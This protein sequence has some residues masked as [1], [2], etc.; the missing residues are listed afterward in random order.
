VIS[1]PRRRLVYSWGFSDTNIWR[2]ELLGPTQAA[3]RSALISSSR[4]DSMPEYSPDG[5]RVSFTSNRS[6]RAEIWTC[7]SDGSN[8]VQVTSLEEPNRFDQ[9]WSPDG[10]YVIFNSASAGQSYLYVVGA[11]GGKAQRLAT[12]ASS[13]SR[14]SWSRDGRW[15]YFTSLR[16][17]Q[18]QVWKI[19][20]TPGAGRESEAVQVTQKGGLFAMESPDGRHVY[21]ANSRANPGLWRVPAQR[22]EEIQVLPALDD[23]GSFAVA[24]RGIYF[25]PPR[26]ADRT[27]PI[28]FLEFATGKT[29]PVVTIDKP[30]GPRLAVSPDGRSLLYH[31]V[32]QQSRDLMLVE[33]FR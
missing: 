30:M 11:E 33:N 24:E 15:I 20:W 12:G 29:F 18:Y 16:T 5:K 7:H 2:I 13:D 22:G 6:G 1:G 9:R 19:P 21:Y 31:Q 3:S 25:M 17:G 28:Q 8:C 26:N 4:I 14:G 32:D 23:P 27:H 10:K